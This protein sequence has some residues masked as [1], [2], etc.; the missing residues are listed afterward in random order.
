M[1]NGCEFM[2]G[3]KRPILLEK[4][5][6]AASIF[7]CAFREAK[8]VENASAGEVQIGLNTSA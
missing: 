6:K 7:G 1:V 8:G 3:G 4:G 2:D 5:L